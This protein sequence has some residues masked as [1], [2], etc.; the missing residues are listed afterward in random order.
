MLL[1][2]KKYNTPQ[3]EVAIYQ[4]IGGEF[5]NGRVIGGQLINKF[6]DHNLIVDTASILMACRMCPGAITGGADEAF[7]GAFLDKGLQYLAVG[8]GILQD[9]A[10]PYD[11]TT[12]VVDLTAWDVMNPPDPTLGETKLV[13][14]FYRKRFTSWKFQD[15]AGEETDTPTNILLIDTTFYENEAC[16]PWTEIGLYGG[17]SVDWN[18]GAGKDSGILFNLK[19]FPVINKQSNHRISVRWKLT[20]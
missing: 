2:E 12:N 14:E 7:E 10:N 1:D 20:F 18:N 17:D 15:A 9:P 19:R 16:G 13:G 6:E 4:Y 3:G 11:A 8:C 5:K